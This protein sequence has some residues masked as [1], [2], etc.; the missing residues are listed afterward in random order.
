MT[1]EKPK[2]TVK[3]VKVAKEGKAKVLKLA[4]E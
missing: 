2:A 4:E 1:E 3:A